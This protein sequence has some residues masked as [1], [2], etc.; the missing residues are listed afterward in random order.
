[1]DMKARILVVDDNALNRKLVQADGLKRGIAFPT[2]CS[3]NHVAAH[4]TPNPG[5]DVFLTDQDVMKVD[6]GTQIDGYIIDCAWTVAFQPRFDPLL[7]AVK[8]ATATGIREAGV[9]VRLCD[10]GAA[11]QETMESFEVELDGETYQVKPIENLNGPSIGRYRIHAGKS[12]PLVGGGAQTKMEEGEFYAIETFGSVRG[13][14]K[15][16]EDGDC[17]HYMKNFEAPYVPL[18]STGAK[19]LLAH[20]N[21]QYDTLAFCKRFLAYDG[22]DKFDGFLGQL[23]SKG[24]VDAYP[25]LVD[26]AGAYTA[27]EEHTIILKPCGK[28]I[29]SRGDDY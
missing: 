2:G 20:I 7:E 25:P 17:S 15:V 9:D 29:I 4:Y 13:R 16:V 24:I 28:E 18:R 26:K 23:V 1:M 8:E 10:V 22:L 27:Q 12:V 3:L 5:E 6:F 11:I 19:K 21:Q 14:A